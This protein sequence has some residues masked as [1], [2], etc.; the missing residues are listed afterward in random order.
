MSVFQFPFHFTKHRAV[1]KV[2]TALTTVTSFWHEKKISSAGNFLTRLS[3]E[4]IWIVEN[5]NL[6]I[7]YCLENVR[8]ISWFTF[9]LR[10]LAGYGGELPLEFKYSTW[11]LMEIP[12]RKHISSIF[13]LIVLPFSKTRSQFKLKS[14]CL[15]RHLS[16][17]RTQAETNRLRRLLFFC[18]PLTVHFGD[19]WFLP[20]MKKPS[21]VYS[22][23]LFSVPYFSVRS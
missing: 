19:L 3:R 21:A 20:G 17:T 23:R 14:S 10:R 1:P 9:T 16:G 7:Y 8:L 4:E 11:P 22:L 13:A 6:M 18:W 2:I 12:S 15:S 5:V